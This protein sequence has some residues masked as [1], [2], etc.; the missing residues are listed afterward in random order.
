MLNERAEPKVSGIFALTPAESKRLIAKAVVRLPEVVAA[1]GTGRIVVANGTT[2]AFV[3]AELLGKDVPWFNYAAG[4][5]CDGLLAET[6]KEDRLLPYVFDKGEVVEVGIRDAV[7]GC[8]R[9]DVFIKGANAVDP[10]GNVGIAM[11]DDRG[12]TIGSSLSVITAR[13]AYL[14]CPVGLEKLVPNVPDA[15]RK[16]GIYR[17]QY[18][19]GSPVG[20]MPVTNAKVVT[21]IEALRLLTG[22]AATHVASGGVGGSE[23]AVVLVAEGNEAQVASTIKLVRE[24]KEQTKNVEKAGPITWRPV[25]T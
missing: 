17:F 7:L 1:Y 9:H 15:A 23:G 6:N 21:E 16:C 12:G 20:L 13:G 2:N 19:L 8:R 24:I 10:Q 4:V 22:V 25:Q 18:A 5:I 14:V 3:A 11:A